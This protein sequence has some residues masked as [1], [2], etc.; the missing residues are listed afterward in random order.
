MMNPQ[1]SSRKAVHLTQLLHSVQQVQR[2]LTFCSSWTRS[3]APR[4]TTHHQFVCRVCASCGSFSCM[5]SRNRKDPLC[6]FISGFALP[7]TLHTK[8]HESAAI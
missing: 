8:K 7:R 2:S 6:S 4:A 3:L 1:G 5:G